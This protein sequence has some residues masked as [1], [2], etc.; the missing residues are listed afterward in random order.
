M[1]RSFRKFWQ[2]N[3]YLEIHSPKL[4][5]A[6][7]ESGANVFEVKYFDRK[8]YLAQSP[9]FYKQMAM[10]AGFEKVF[11]V[12]PVFRA[13]PS[14]TTRHSTEFIGYDAEISYINSYQDVISEIEKNIENVKLNGPRGHKRL[15]NN[16]NFSFDF[17]E[18]ES[19]LL[20]LDSKGIAVST[21]SACSSK[22]LKPSHVLL[23]IGLKPETAH[24]SI[25]FSFSRYTTKQQL[26]YTIK[27]L[28]N[29]VA[30]LRQMSPLTRRK[31]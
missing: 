13:E 14:F 17:I 31:K 6:P 10:A 1:E 28:K 7:S 27:E 12:G 4:M 18:G 16:V 9:Q 29:T 25:R 2:D 11:E 8:A 19:I 23:A 3:D 24:G 26:D 30:K 20:I 21:G 15:C 22:D 5:N